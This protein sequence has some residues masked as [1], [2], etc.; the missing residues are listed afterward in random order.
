MT[1][2]FRFSV[3]TLV[4]LVTLLGAYFGTWEATKTFVKNE[5]SLPKEEWPIH[6]ERQRWYLSDA[7]AP[8]PL[9]ICQKESRYEKKW[10]FRKCYYLWLLSH[11]TKNTS[12]T[13]AW[14]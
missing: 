10:E 8:L 6:P 3:R 12:F 11:A 1:R 2:R 5:N 4:I 14:S 13:S 7:T 9:I